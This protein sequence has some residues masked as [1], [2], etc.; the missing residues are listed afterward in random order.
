MLQ[1]D[2]SGGM[3]RRE[4]FIERCMI[5]SMKKFCGPL[6][7]RWSKGRNLN[8]GKRRAVSMPYDESHCIGYQE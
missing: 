6:N 2:I 3:I 4:R 8:G 7:R 1:L 5:M